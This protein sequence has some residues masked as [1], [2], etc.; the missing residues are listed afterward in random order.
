MGDLSTLSDA[1]LQTLRGLAPKSASSTIDLQNLSDDQLQMLRSRAGMDFTPGEQGADA[2]KTIVPGLARGVAAVPGF[3]GD[4]ERAGRGAY[5]WATGGGSTYPAMTPNASGKVP[6]APSYLFPSSGDIVGGIERDV[7]GPW[8][9]PK[10]PLGKYTNTLAEFA[11]TGALGPEGAAVKVARTLGGAFGSESMGEASAGTPYEPLYRFLGG[12]VGGGVAPRAI[13]PFPSNVERADLVGVLNQHGITALNAGQITGNA[14]LN[15]AQDVVDKLPFSGGRIGAQNEEAGR[16]FTS[17]VMGLA[18][19]Q[20]GTMA[21]QANIDAMHNRISGQYQYYT[22]RNNIQPDPQNGWAPFVNRV[23]TAAQNYYTNVLPMNRSNAV[24][25][26]IQDIQY[27]LATN[28]VI[29]GPQYQQIRSQIRASARSTTDPLTRRTMTEVGNALDDEM[30]RSIGQNNPADLGGFQETNRQYRNA[31]VVDQTRA[32]AGERTAEGFLSPAKYRSVVDN[33]E[34]DTA[35]ARGM[36]DHA[37]LANASQILPEP[38]TSTTSE[39]SGIRHMVGEGGT[40]LAAGITAHE[41]GGDPQHVLAAVAAPSIVGRAVNSAPVQ[42]YLGNQF[43]PRGQDPMSLL[44][45]RALAQSQA[46]QPSQSA[47]Q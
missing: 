6:G 11:P 22:S 19:E 5:D 28:G 17:A 8:Y 44:L 39:R 23:N 38:R 15:Q 10:T 14:K 12:A 24:A 46:N 35:Y 2:L 40:A 1:D 29:T 45:A 34:G 30:E 13:T 27:R 43:L 4:V 3:P 9:Q 26:T 16:Q 41:L 42:G 7:T 18:G 37:Q 32:A 47:G 33:M 36:G 25:S 21:S 31:L 20:P